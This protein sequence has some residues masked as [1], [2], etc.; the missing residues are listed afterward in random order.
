MIF[1]P[2]IWLLRDLDHPRVWIPKSSKVF[3]ERRLI[4]RKKGE[5]G[6]QHEPVKTSDIEDP[7]ESSG[8]WNVEGIESHTISEL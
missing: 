3:K 2:V 5:I 1:C 8:S 4:I 7:T 6:T